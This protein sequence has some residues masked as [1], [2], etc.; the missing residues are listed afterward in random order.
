MSEVLQ[1]VRPTVNQDLVDQMR[2][3]LSEAERG[4]FT[5]AMVVA[6]REGPTFVIR[7]IGSCSD[8][9]LAGALA[10]AQ[11]DLIEANKPKPK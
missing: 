6:M 3:L 10:F 2:K 1:L 9:E 5:S 8:L 11:Y 4:E 7:R